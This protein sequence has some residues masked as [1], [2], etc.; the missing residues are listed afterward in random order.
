MGV[1]CLYY[2]E[3]VASEG[4]HVIFK[5]IAQ[6]IRKHFNITALH[7][8]LVPIT[9][10]GYYT[11]TVYDLVNGSVIGPVLDSTQLEVNILSSS[12]NGM[13]YLYEIV[14]CLVHSC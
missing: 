8:K 12:M 4:C 6:G 11:V 9:N 14:L 13:Y 5:D 1:Q 7:E 3:P 2:C 10:N